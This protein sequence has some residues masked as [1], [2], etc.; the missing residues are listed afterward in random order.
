MKINRDDPR[1]TAYVLEEMSADERAAFER[2]MGMDPEARSLVDE[3]RHTSQLLEEGLAAEKAQAPVHGRLTR[4]PENVV[5]LLHRDWIWQAGMAAAFVICA[6]ALFMLLKNANDNMIALHKEAAREELAQKKAMVLAQ[7]PEILI[8]IRRD[9]APATATQEIQRQNP[10]YPPATS[11]VVDQ[12]G[13]KSPNPAEIFAE[14]VELAQSEPRPLKR[15]GNSSHAEGFVDAQRQYLSSFPLQ[16]GAESYEYVMASIEQ[17]ALPDARHVQVEQLVNAFGYSQIP[18]SKAQELQTQ[19]EVGVCPWAPNHRL[20]RIVL[21]GSEDVDSADLRPEV[22]FNP[23]RVSRYRLI[24]S[25]GEGTDIS[26]G[27]TG[28]LDA[29]KT[30]TALYEVVPIEVDYMASIPREA[31][32]PGSM[33]VKARPNSKVI[34]SMQLGFGSES[35]QSAELIDSPTSLSEASADF[36]FAAAVAAFGMK[37]RSEDQVSHFSYQRI[38]QLAKGAL[39]ESAQQEQR[40]QFVELVQKTAKLDA[41]AR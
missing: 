36:R 34:L 30:V 28:N 3:I 19:L 24:G 9:D 39:G 1:W 40:Q 13:L 32:N 29:G 26:G 7:T 6:G 41:E 5:P 33:G 14:E 18:S 37:L 4:Q 11:I 21:R 35:G 2:E 20:V 15:P 16:I 38:Q 23:M 17:G 27:A 8:Q 10:S 22:V 25:M 31:S 12:T